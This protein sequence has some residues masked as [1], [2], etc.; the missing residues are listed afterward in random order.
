MKSTVLW[1]AGLVAAALISGCGGPGNVALS[2]EQPDPSLA[3]LEAP[4]IRLVSPPVWKAGE[5]VTVLGAGFVPQERGYQVVRLD[6]EFVEDGGQSRRVAMSVRAEFRNAGR[7]EFVFEPAFPPDGFGYDIGQFVGLI[8]A[9]NADDVE[10]SPPSEPLDA[11]FD[12][13]P[14]LIIWGLA[15]EGAPCGNGPRADAA[16]DGQLMLLDLEAIGL[17]PATAYTPLDFSVSYVDFDNNIREITDKLTGGRSTRFE[18]VAGPLPYGQVQGG[19]HLN[20]EVVDGHGERRVRV[21]SLD[22]A[23]DYSVAYDGNTRLAEL[24]A[25]IQVSGC[26]PG[27]EYG[28]NVSYTASESESRSRSVG[29]NASIGVDLWVFNVGFGI[30]VTETVSSNQSQS[31]S[32]SGTILPGQYGVFYRQTQR[33]ERLGYIMKRNRCGEETVV[34]DAR[35]TDWNWAPD[36]AITA[37]GS[38]PP[39]PPSNLPQA[40]VI[41]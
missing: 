14:S 9:A 15:P 35:V 1:Q 34:G 27:G 19:M 22:I 28:R 2:L 11:A 5:V 33:V 23:R 16:L 4:S 30:N 10:T 3:P 32:L 39:A 38:C 36:L 29:Y 24:M 12:V 13:G 20:I 37:N 17:T 25:P 41:P 6:G 8:T 21:L 26:L 18:I 7:I 40:Q 31:L